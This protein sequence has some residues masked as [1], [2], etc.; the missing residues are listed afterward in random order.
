MKVSDIVQM[1]SVVEYNYR[2]TKVD[3][4]I[5]GR[6]M[7]RIRITPCRAIG[8]IT[9]HRGGSKLISP[10]TLNKVAKFLYHSQLH[11]EK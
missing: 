4:M 11:Y 8:K 10:Q 3:C 6:I 5:T 2:N 9:K 1:G 7:N